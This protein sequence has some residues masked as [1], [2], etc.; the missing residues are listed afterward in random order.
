MKGTQPQAEAAVWM[1][2]ECV[3]GEAW[4]SL[5]GDSRVWLYTADRLLTSEEQMK[6]PD[7]IESFLSDWVAHGQSLRASWRLEGGRCLVVAL[8]EQSPQATGC[9]I[10]AKVHWLQALGQQWGIDWMTRNTVM[11]YDE[12]ASNWQEMPLASFWAARKAGRI[13][14]ETEVINSVV[15][16]KLECDPTLVCPFSASWH[17]AMWR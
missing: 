3:Q 1:E 2:G 17:E 5:S 16:K 4:A 11:F 13:H 9:S 10:D 8:D 6:L 7:A 14:G 12:V 15:S